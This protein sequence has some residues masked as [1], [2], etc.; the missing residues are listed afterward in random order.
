MLY[1]TVSLILR[2]ASKLFK[3]KIRFRQCNSSKKDNTRSRHSQF[4]S[5]EHKRKLCSFNF[6]QTVLQCRKR[7]KMSHS[8][9]LYMYVATGMSTDLLGVKFVGKSRDFFP[10]CPNRRHCERIAGICFPA[11]FLLTVWIFFLLLRCL[12]TNQKKKNM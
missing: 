7:Q 4:F 6:H 1:L 11:A 8:Y 3:T 5:C 10:L 2:S 12:F 9:H